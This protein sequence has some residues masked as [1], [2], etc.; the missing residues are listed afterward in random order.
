M[1]GIISIQIRTGDRIVA[2]TI[3]ER[4]GQARPIRHK[5][6]PSN[7]ETLTAAASGVVLEPRQIE[8][9]LAVP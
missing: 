3:T 6:A 5:S 2:V 7:V 8:N 4:G 9:P 1:I